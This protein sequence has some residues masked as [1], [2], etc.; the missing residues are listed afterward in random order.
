MFREVSREVVAAVFQG[1][2]LLHERRGYQNTRVKSL[3]AGR[4]AR[5]KSFG[6]QGIGID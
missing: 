6:C 2:L 4:Q 3:S 1:L 5:S